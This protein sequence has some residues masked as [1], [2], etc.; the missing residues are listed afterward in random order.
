MPDRQRKEDCMAS[1]PR[2]LHRIGHAAAWPRFQ[3]KLEP[4]TTCSRFKANIVRTTHV[5]VSVGKM[6]TLERKAVRFALS[7]PT[8]SVRWRNPEICYV[9]QRH[10]TGQPDNRPTNAR[11]ILYAWARNSTLRSGTSSPLSKA[12]VTFLRQMAG[13]PKGT[14]LSS[15][16]AGVTLSVRCQSANQKQL[17][18]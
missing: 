6:T 4:K 2:T 11:R 16:M 15:I 8:R 10:R 1:L 3:C 5:S 17:R 7:K 12:A 13:N 14:T 18:L 9:R